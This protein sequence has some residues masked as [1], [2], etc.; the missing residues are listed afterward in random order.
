MRTNNPP[1][2]GSGQSATLEIASDL[3]GQG[4]GHQMFADAEARA[5]TAGCGLMQ[6][7]MNATR[8]ESRRFYEALGF[9]ASHI[10]FKKVLG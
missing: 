10:G 6:L 2:A 3:R 7:T 8:Q 1:A 9:E 4:L 5:R